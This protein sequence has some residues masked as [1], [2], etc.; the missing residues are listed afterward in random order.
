M[1]NKEMLVQILKAV[2]S[3]SLIVRG[4]VGS[5]G[6]IDRHGESINPMGW[7][8]ENYLKNPVILWGHDY[9]ALPIGKAVK[10]WIENEQLMFD[11][12]LSKTYEMGKKVFDLIQEGIVRTVSVGFIPLKL[13]ESGKYTWAEQELLEL[14]FVTV[15]ANPSALTP[16][17]KSLLGNVEELFKMK[18]EELKDEHKNDDAESDAE[19]D[20]DAGN[21]DDKGDKEAAG[22]EAEAG[23][24]GDGSEESSD[25]PAEKTIT[26]TQDEVKSLIEDTV[27]ETLKQYQSISKAIKE[28]DEHADDSSV[29]KTDKSLEV[30]KGLQSVLRGSDK[31]IGLAL[32]SLNEALQSTKKES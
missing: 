4:V 31:E 23:T 24:A 1:K 8:L 9:R 14:S 10:V 20:G 27:A 7:K 6:M 16:E 26:L 21:S 22:D 2:D 25:E 5:N 12:A 19:A 3:E 32:R 11:I 29:T 17:Q 13:D 15:P 28:E 18:A 30:L